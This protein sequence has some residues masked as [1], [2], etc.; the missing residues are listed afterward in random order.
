MALSRR[1]QIATRWLRGQRNGVSAT[2]LARF[3]SGP[4]CEIN[5]RRYIS[6]VEQE[7]DFLVVR[8]RG[9]DRP[10]YWPKE[11][12]IYA[13]HM[14]LSEALDERNWHFYEV[15]ETRVQSDDVV[16]DCGAAEGIFS[17]LVQERARQVYAIEPAPHWTASLERTFA[18][19]ANVRSAGRR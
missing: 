3:L 6:T 14:V 12:P 8:L 17:L 13:L 7:D 10:L 5:S 2:D 19:A 1:L 16:A 9:V 18:G 4:T 15:P 11:Q